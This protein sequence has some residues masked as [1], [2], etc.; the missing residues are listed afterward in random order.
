MCNEDEGGSQL[1]VDIT[2]FFEK[3]KTADVPTVL[4]KY[5]QLCTCVNI[6]DHIRKMDKWS[7]NNHHNKFRAYF[8][9]DCLENNIT[10]TLF[11]AGQNDYMRNISNWTSSDFVTKSQCH[12]LSIG[13]EKSSTY[14]KSSCSFTL[15]TLLQKHVKDIQGIQS[16]R[17]FIEEYNVELKRKVGNLE[18][19]NQK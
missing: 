3:D 7:V 11:A 13:P 15:Q 4:E 8:E 18:K 12:I 17:R 9:P 10:S 6:P 2:K 14:F 1:N 16:T 5:R 19:H